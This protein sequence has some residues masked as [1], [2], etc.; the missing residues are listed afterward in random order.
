MLPSTS[1]VTATEQLTRSMLRLTISQGQM[2]CSVCV[3]SRVNSVNA[4]SIARTRSILSPNRREHRR[5]LRS[6]SFRAENF[7]YL[8]LPV[9]SDGRFRYMA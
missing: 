8:G 3:C 9:A 4:S 5:P 6:V 1:G 2:Q 7:P